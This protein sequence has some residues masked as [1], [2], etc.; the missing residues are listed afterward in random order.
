MNSI[1]FATAAN[2]YVAGQIVQGQVPQHLKLI[3]AHITAEGK[4]ISAKLEFAAYA[5][6]RR[7]TNVKTGD[8]GRADAF[9]FTIWGPAAL[10][11]AK[12]LTVGK[13]ITV[14][15]E[16][17]SY[18]GRLFRPDGQQVIDSLGQPVMANKVNFNVDQFE[19]GND[20][21]KWVE[22][23]IMMGWRPAQWNNP[24]HPDNAA[25]KNE[26]ARRMALTWDGRSGSFCYARMIA[27][28]GQIDMQ[29][30]VSSGTKAIAP[31]VNGFV[32]P[33]APPVFNQAPVAPP[34]YN[35]ASAPAFG[36][37][38]APQFNTAPVNNGF[39]Q[40]APPMN[41]G[42]GQPAPGVRKLF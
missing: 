25:W 4:K 40:A 16:P 34:M 39:G 37:P 20:G 2:I 28:S 42:F 32:A 36:A 38:V 21:A 6:F 24:Q 15:C 22:Y 17:R 30:M 13:M 29:S 1:F 8:S 9:K 3:P 35:N 27:P 18:I 11:G 12:T 31:V 14:T 41:T 7:G 5:N 33:A 23:E 10:L 19:L 26:I